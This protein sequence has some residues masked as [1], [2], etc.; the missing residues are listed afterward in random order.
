MIFG[1]DRGKDMERKISWS[2][3]TIFVSMLS[4]Y[5]IP[6]YYFDS[7]GLPVSSM[8]FGGFLVISI[9]LYIKNGGSINVFDLIYIILIMFCI[10]YQK[11]ISPLV[12][13]TPLV[14]EKCLNK[15]AVSSIRK[16]LLSS[17]LPYIALIF[18]LIYSVWYGISTG[19]FVHTGIYEVNS[20]GL[21]VFLLGLI[22]MKRN[23]LLGKIVLLFGCL[24]LSRNYILSNLIYIYINLKKNN[25]FKRHYKSRIFNFTFLMIFTG[26]ILYILGGICQYKFSQGAIVYETTFWGRLTN[27]F[28]TSNYLRFS[29]NY[30][31]IEI[32]NHN[33]SLWLVGCKNDEFKI[34]CLLYAVQN[35]QKYVGNNP[36][37]F[38][39]SYIKLYGMA[40]VIDVFYVGKLFKK[41]LRKENFAI[42][43]AVFI[44]CIFLSVGANGHWLFLTL[45]VMILYMDDDSEEK[46]G[47]EEEK[48][49]QQS[50]E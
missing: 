9:L 25:F 34:R 31:L 11:S 13:L 36:H 41:F 5:I 22:F 40:G 48:N 21:A 6:D 28:D 45:S 20:S 46:E 2:Y 18:T 50:A 8:L 49:I 15:Q 39:F 26:M 1:S 10:V 12:L 32:F 30:Y 24:S 19:R 47:Y 4:V 7:L 33:P 37:N 44:Y 35:G 38:L 23:K 42:Y 16:I 17:N 3:M 27:F 29:V 14:A 43:F